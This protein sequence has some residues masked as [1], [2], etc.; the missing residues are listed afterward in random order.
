MDV[1]NIVTLLTLLNQTAALAAKLA[2]IAKTMQAEGRTELT[3]EE[4]ADLRVTDDS[5]AAALDAAIARAKA[6][7]R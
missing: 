4:L 7:R 1:M 2:A 5:A 3:A 6:E